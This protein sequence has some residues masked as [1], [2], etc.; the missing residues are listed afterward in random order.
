[1]VVIIKMKK[2]V[3]LVHFIGFPCNLSGLKFVS[4]I[5]KSFCAKVLEVLEHVALSNL[6]AIR[7][8]KFQYFLFVKKVIY[9][10]SLLSQR[11][12]VKRSILISSHK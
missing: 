6:W 1:V 4:L 10:L 11:E 9:L 3:F 7:S 8:L 5:K 12:G 2:L